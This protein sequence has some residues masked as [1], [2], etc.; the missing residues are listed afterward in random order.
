MT[1]RF[2]IVD[3]FSD[4]P[5]AG[6]PVAV[7]FDAE[8]LD[9][10]AMMRITRWLNLSETTFLQPSTVT[11]ADYRVRIFTLERELPFAGHPTLGSVHA[12]LMAGGVPQNEQEI[13]QEC[14]AGLVRIRREDDRLL[15]AAPPLERSGPLPDARLQEIQTVLGV[16]P[17]A[18][19]DS[20]WCDNGPGWAAVLMH[21]ANDVLA[22]R[23]ARSH[24]TRLEIGVV[25][26]Y[27]P[28]SPEAFELRAFFS[29]QHGIL[30]E[31]PVTGSLNAAVAQWL[32]GS[33]RVRAPY[34]A[35]QGTCVGS[36]GRVHIAEDLVGQ[37]WVGGTARTLVTGEI[38]TGAA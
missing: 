26:P 27:P 2:H 31:D 11:E 14:G 6:N 13:V 9:H 8:G 10:D 33:G 1:N 4:Q 29:D 19:V 12:W 17:G 18:I 28:G 21:S 23:P 34:V 25:G 7:V 22:L 15:F 24:P 35:S 36:L 3:V 20:Q 16:S 37:I 30:R 38:R 32:V 5:F